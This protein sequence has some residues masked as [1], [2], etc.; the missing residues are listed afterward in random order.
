MRSCS[1]RV[2]S[3]EL[4]GLKAARPLAVCAQVEQ[5]QISSDHL[6]E[7]VITLAWNLMAWVKSEM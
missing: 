7:L 5:D 4:R 2:Q 6:T 1:V 3:E